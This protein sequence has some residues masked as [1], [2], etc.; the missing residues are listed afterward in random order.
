MIRTYHNIR[1][2][3]NLFPTLFV[4]F[5]VGI[6]IEV[7]GQA[8][9]VPPSPHA[10]G[11][12][13]HANIPINLNT[14]IANITVPLFDLPAGGI[15]IPINLSYHASGHKVQDIPGPAGLGFTLNAGGAIT[16]IV[17]GLPDE[18]GYCGPQQHGNLD[19]D[20]YYGFG[21]IQSGFYDGEPD[22]FYFNF[23]GRAGK[24]IMN[25]DG[26]PILI[27]KQDIKI[28]PA[29]GVKGEGKWVITDESG[30]QFIF[31]Q[32]ERE[33]ETTTTYSKKPGQSE[34]TPDKTYVSTWYISKVLSPNSKELASFGYQAGD[35]IENESFYDQK[36]DVITQNCDR[37]ERDIERIYYKSSVKPK[38]IDHVKSNSGGVYFLYTSNRQDLTAGKALKTIKILD[39]NN[40]EL[41]QYQLVHDYFYAWDSEYANVWQSASAEEGYRLYLKAINKIKGG[42]I[43]PYR[44]FEYNDTELPPRNSLY[45]DSYGYFNAFFLR[46]SWRIHYSNLPTVNF[47][48]EVFYGAWREPSFRFTGARMLTKINLPLGGYQEFS[49][50][51]NWGGGGI[52]IAEIQE[53]DDISNIITSKS[54]TYEQPQLMSEPVHHYSYKFYGE[55]GPDYGF[56]GDIFNWDN[57]CEVE[58]LIRKSE[59]YAA[60][61]DLNGASVTYGKVIENFMDG[62][63]T[64]YEF[65]NHPDIEP[66]VYTSNPCRPG[67]SCNSDIDPNGAPFAPSTFR[68]YLR[69]LLKK[70]IDL[71]SNGD[72][73]L[74][75]SNNYNFDN[76]EPNNPRPRRGRAPDGPVGIVTHSD[77]QSAGHPVYHV[78]KYYVTSQYVLLESTKRTVFDNER[79]LKLTDS[80]NF[81]YHPVYQS[82]VRKTISENDLGVQ[83]ISTT[84]YPIDYI[85]DCEVE[86]ILCQSQ[87][88]CIETDPQCIECRQSCVTK[89]NLCEENFN[90]EASKPT[91]FKMHDRGIVGSVI[92]QKTT[93]KQGTTEKVIA[94]DLTEYKT[95]GDLIIPGKTFSFRSNE[96]ITG[97][98]DSKLSATGA[99]QYDSRYKLETAFD[100]YDTD[101]NVLGIS[102]HDGLSSSYI[103]GYNNTYPIAQVINAASNEIAYTSFEDETAKGGWDFTAIHNDFSICEEQR[104]ADFEVCLG[105]VDYDERMACYDYAYGI[106]NGCKNTIN[107]T[108]TLVNDKRVTG[109]SSFWRGSIAKSNL[110]PGRYIISFW[111][112]RRVLNTPGKI[113]GT[114]AVDIPNSDWNYYR[115]TLNN[116]TEVTL[117]I[118][119][120]TYLDEL[121]L[122]PAGARMT[123]YTHDPLV[124]V[125][126]ISDENDNSIYY[127]YDKF[128]RLIYVK[129]HNGNIIEHYKY[130]YK[131]Y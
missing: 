4:F 64:I 104:S 117:N 98:T 131:L 39:Y 68:G 81:E 75:I 106:Y 103:Y 121:R 51:N 60:L 99:F 57:D 31:G 111:A 94:A 38:Y 129:D 18:V 91:I 65:S 124:G 89:R 116:V 108:Y 21:G 107:D 24:F 8:Y 20:D 11:L 16:R 115:L 6:P 44:S 120:N 71:N 109:N 46:D 83:M 49:Y 79:Q 29:I 78:G 102:S 130:N 118:D 63:K 48:G 5:A 58:F 56:I 10:A 126:S 122:Y 95:D 70:K 84:K 17:R 86:Y 62:S 34:L 85:P 47:N 74:I 110:P 90:N 32:Y 54:Y 96:G 82:L 69:G 113:T 12:L 22:I 45:I 87:C 50:R 30:F 28:A 7:H 37:P 52:R 55:N 76:I 114:I 40:N 43:E 97:F 33:R 59:S 128:G 35:E 25:G 77:I 88:L 105:I 9:Y 19:L 13:R 112:R 119:S 125:T 26:E 73:V 101:G 15:D 123:S 127:Q 36:R 1:C 53:V 61:N 93:I 2:F 66:S 23:L 27:P 100:K 80:T 67:L 72:T 42:S 3:L 14:G 92:E 41:M